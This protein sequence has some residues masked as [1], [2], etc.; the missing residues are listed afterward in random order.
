MSQ[1]TF[2]NEETLDIYQVKEQ[3]AVIEKRDGELSFRAQKTK[4]YIEEVEQM[5]LK[6]ANDVRKK[7]LALEIPRFKP[8]HIAKII[9]MKPISVED[10]KQLVSSF[11]ITIK[12]DNI[13]EIFACF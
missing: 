11:N 4:E 1:P 5:E 12:D 10:L 13:K 6:Q 3:L 9:D 7:M 2:G 8:D